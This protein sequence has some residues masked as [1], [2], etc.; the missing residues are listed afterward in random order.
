MFFNQ[1]NATKK[2]QEFI[3]RKL[4]SE[5]KKATKAAATTPGAVAP[6]KT[7][8]PPKVIK[9]AKVPS[10]KVTT[11]KAAPE[12]AAS[13]KLSTAHKAVA[14]AIP[15]NVILPIKSAPPSRC[16]ITAPPLADDG[17]ASTEC[18]D[19]TGMT[20]GSTRS[21]DPTGSTNNIQNLDYVKIMTVVN[22]WDKIKTTN[23]YEEA[24]GEQIILKMMELEPCTRDMLGLP[25]LRS[26]RFAAVSSNLV[27]MI[28]VIVFSLGPDMEDDD[29]LELG[30]ICIS[31]GFNGELF[32]ILSQSVCSSL[33]F[34]LGAEDFSPRTEDAWKA[35]MDFMTI[36]MSPPKQGIVE[37]EL[38]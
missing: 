10:A 24:L 32:R 2:A 27:G 23:G 11:T 21:S 17:S 34:V 15:T 30:M 33:K 38:D 26:P 4:A 8:A 6:T 18:T 19:S 1:R 31:E 5:K 20:N 22:S 3:E 9:N 35:V 16:S 37:Q 29:L 12:A 7:S 13:T 25:S 14:N 36:N 28:D